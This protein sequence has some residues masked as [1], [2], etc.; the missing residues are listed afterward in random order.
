MDRASSACL[1]LSSNRRL[2]SSV[3]WFAVVIVHHNHGADRVVGYY[4]ASDPS[5]H[6]GGW[7]DT[8]KGHGSLP[9]ASSVIVGAL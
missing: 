7:I 1:F 4:V 3:C 2:C 6:V 8:M 9:H 5:K